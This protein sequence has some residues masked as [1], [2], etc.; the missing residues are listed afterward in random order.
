MHTSA[1]AIALAGMLT[2]TAA[3]DG[4]AW[5][6]EYRQA[7]QAGQKEAKPL[8]VFI[9][10]GKAGWDQVSREGG[11]APDVKDVLRQKYVCLYVDTDREAGKKL[12]AAFEMES[13][14][15]IVISARDGELQAFRH[16]GD[17][18]NRDLAEY[19]NRYADPGRAVTTTETHLQGYASRYGAEPSEPAAQ[20]TA[21]PVNTIVP[22]IGGGGCSS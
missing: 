16:E 22:S 18:R 10:S 9:G 7:R 12:A 14:P 6:E 17:L 20:P 2:P 15:G 3:T 4:P 13:G 8:A 11:L 5:H 21:I 19:L 1:L